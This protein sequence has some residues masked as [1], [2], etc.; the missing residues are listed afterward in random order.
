MIVLFGAGVSANPKCIEEIELSNTGAIYSWEFGL[1]SPGV[2]TLYGYA[3]KSNGSVILPSCALETPANRKVVIPVILVDWADYNPA[4]DLSNPNNLES[5]GDPNYRKATRQEISDFLNG[6]DGPA[7]YYEDVSS[8]RFQIEFDVLDWISSDHELSYIKNRSEYLYFHSITDRWQCYQDNLMEDAIRSAISIHNV[9]FENYDIDSAE[10]QYLEKIVDGAVFMYEGQGGSCSGMNMSWLAGATTDPEDTASGNYGIRL[11]NVAEMVKPIDPNY[12]LFSDQNAMV[13]HYINLPEAS[14]FSS[15]E[16]DV[17]GITH[18]VGHLLLGF[19]DYYHPKHNIYAWGLSGSV[20]KQAS[21]PGA[22]EKEIFGGWIESEILTSSGNY[23]L[24]ANDIADGTEYSGNYLY[25]IPVAEGDDKYLT[26]EYRWFK[27][28]GNTATK[29]ASNLTSNLT[30][31]ESGLTIIEFDWSQSTFDII[32]AF[33]HAPKRGE[34]SNRQNLAFKEGDDFYKCF[35]NEL[36]VGISNI[37]I[38]NNIASFDANIFA[39]GD[40]DHCF[41]DRDVFPED[42]NECDDN[43][44]DGVGDNADEDDDNDGMPDEWEE[45]YNLDPK[46]PSDADSDLDSDGDSN[47]TEYQNGTNPAIASISN[48]VVESESSPGGGAL[49]IV[50]LI[51]MTIARRFRCQQVSS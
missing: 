51:L 8:G 45:N 16:P 33:R 46:D 20:A 15:G 17:G 35:A 40:G 3:T 24:D 28:Q 14:I 49:G 11:Q 22:W 44:S 1:R 29:W 38:N 23:E 4:T 48:P 19:I 41:D 32:N 42:P 10:H 18:E 21:H 5:H 37:Q 2:S 25:R 43:D 26:I 34:E 7:Q 30:S 12:S 50:F 27:D 36:C 6:P 39:D 13:N 9:R 31:R 47:L